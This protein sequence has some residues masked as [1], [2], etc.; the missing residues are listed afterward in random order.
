MTSIGE[1]Y[2]PKL[3][4]KRW[5]RSEES[6]IIEL[7][8]KEGIYKF[9]YDINDPR[10]V[11]VFDTPP[12][13]TSGPW[14]VGNLAH[15]IQIDIIGRYFRMRG[16]NVLLPFYADRNGLPVEVQVERKYNLN[17]HEIAS[18]HSGREYFLNICK[19]ELDAIEKMLIDDLINSGCSFE[20]WSSGTD[21]PNYRRITQATFIELFKHGLIYEAERPVNWCPRCRTTL[22][23]AELEYKSSLT[24]LYYIKF[25][26]Y[27]SGES[28]VIATTRPE[29]L[30]ACAILI[31]NPNDD[32]YKYLKGK[33]AIIPIYE[34]IVPIVER[35]EARPEFGT[36]LAMI[37]SY[38]D[39]M[40]VRIFRDMFLEPRLII[41]R[42][43]RMN[44]FSGFL[45]GLTISEARSRIVEELKL[46]NLIVKVE[47]FE[48]E[49]PVC[50][51][52]KTPIEFIHAKEYFLKQVEFKEDLKKII[53]LM[54][55]YP[56]EHKKRLLDWVESISTDWPIS[57]DRYY[58]TEVPVWKCKECNSIL[59]PEVGGYYRPWIDKPPFES[60]FNC[61]ALNDKIYGEVKVLD[62]W[63]D[64]SI[65]VLYVSKYGENL[66]NK[67]FPNTVRPQGYDIIRT[68]LYY[69]L[70]RIY[71]LLKKPA[72]KYVRISGMG[73][74]EKGE[75][76]HK[77]KGNVIDPK[78][79]INKYGIDAFR[80]WAA[81]AS[82]LGS[83]YRFSEQL[84]KTGALF[85]TKLWN[86]ARFISSFPFPNL[87]ELKFRTIDLAMISAFNRL[88]E[89]CISAYDSMDTYIPA[90]EIYNFTWNL[91]ASHYIEA[92]KSRA[93]NDD[94][95]YCE[96]EQ[97][98]SWYTLHFVF[99][100]ILKLLAPIMP[101]ITESIWRKIYSEKSIHVERII[102]P[103]PEWNYSTKALELLI[104]AN[105]K[106]WSYKKNLGLS[107]SSPLKLEVV[108]TIE[109]K[110]I[111]EELKDLHLLE[112]YKII[113]DKGESISFK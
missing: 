98:A 39:N 2:K 109:Y 56:E 108:F 104:S 72:F 74:D 75:A 105:S 101:I 27:E 34:G 83:D 47:D 68:W 77:S 94:G 100:N 21:S 66:F 50:W 29:L 26:V 48:H 87:N 90:T 12:P 44:E 22:A 65:T 78:P 106:I 4:S 111:I 20:Y 6:K 84:I 16:Y 8:W 95:K 112:N 60:C 24:K 110:D 3:L 81:A 15:Y 59:L 49:F 5:D 14:N 79:Y 88:I 103:N 10:P 82:K 11:I 28:I 55:F 43:G 45:K 97:K 1:K 57:K 41:D 25:K 17:I 80:F 96:N 38:G 9:N 69:S 62:T 36:G 40:D 99:S 91:F 32:R 35:Y 7:W 31:Y 113:E 92:V 102:N 63:F 30:G 89:K 70:L 64:S 53:D 61:G 73:L 67:L 51:R 76:M 19:R 18:T 42:D 23:D 86:I 54:I 37:C 33:H 58:A 93:Y 85:I 107:L 46:R 71:Q 13:Y 52:C